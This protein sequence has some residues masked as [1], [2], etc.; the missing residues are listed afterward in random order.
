MARPKKTFWI[1]TPVKTCME[2]ISKRL[3]RDKF[4]IKQN[5]FFVKVNNGYKKIAEQNRNRIIRIDGSKP[6]NH[7]FN[8]IIEELGYEI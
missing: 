1:D 8:L 7:I 2:R 6:T 4:E 3:K 5:A